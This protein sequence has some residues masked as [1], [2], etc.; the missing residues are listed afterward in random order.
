MLLYITGLKK[1]VLIYFGYSCASVYRCH[2][3]REAW[4]RSGMGIKPRG[5]IR[6]AQ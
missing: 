2:M 5:S 3:D 4:P 6:C 1:H